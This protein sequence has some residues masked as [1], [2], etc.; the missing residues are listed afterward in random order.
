VRAHPVSIAMALVCMAIAFLAASWPGLGAT[1]LGLVLPLAA[2][3]FAHQ[4]GSSGSSNVLGMSWSGSPE[5][6][7]RLVGWILL[8]AILSWHVVVG[9][10]IAFPG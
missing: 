3:W 5:R 10:P 1:L 4:L 9:L 6:G 7:V 2:I 8:V